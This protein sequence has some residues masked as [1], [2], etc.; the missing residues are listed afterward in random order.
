MDSW[1][2]IH[3]L[4]V[5]ESSRARGALRH[6]LWPEPDITMSGEAANPDEALALAR[7]HRFDVALVDLSL[8]HAQAFALL[9]GLA[10]QC[11]GIALIALTEAA[12]AAEAG[13]A[14]AHGAAACLA[15]PEVG[16]AL[17]QAIRN[18]VAQCARRPVHQAPRRAT[19]V[20]T[21]A[22]RL[23]AIPID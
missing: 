6:A 19:G 14:R 7:V 18:A 22:R 15:K 8:P 16:R 11:P 1:S 5:A 20:S 23:A 13:A 3:V 17:A 10:R 4:V 21:I 12:D 2:L 9:R